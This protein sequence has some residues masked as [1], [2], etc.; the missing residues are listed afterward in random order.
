MKV[1]DYLKSEDVFLFKNCKSKSDLYKNI[2]P[3]SVQTN[4]NEKI[5][6]DKIIKIIDQRE[7]GG[8]LIVK[9]GI[10]MPHARLENI[11]SP[12][13]KF[14]YIKDGIEFEPGRICNFV[15]L[16]ITPLDKSQT[17]LQIMAK[18]LTLFKKEEMMH[19]IKNSENPKDI[20]EIIKQEENMGNI[21]Y[22]SMTKEQVFIELGT[23]VSGFTDEELIEK[24]SKEKNGGFSKL[25]EKLFSFFSSQKE[26]TKIPE[27]LQQFIPLKTKVIRSG[28]KIEIE[29]SELFVGDVV[30][31]EKGDIITAD[32]RVIETDDMKVDN[33][34]L[35]G[36]SIDIYKNS[37]P[38]KT[39]LN[40]LWEELPNMIFAGTRVSRGSGKAIVVATGMNT[41][42]GIT[43]AI[44]QTSK[45]R[46]EKM[47]ELSENILVKDSAD[48]LGTINVICT[49]K[50]GILTIDEMS[51]SRLY[52]NEKEYSISGEGYNP[53]GDYYNEE[54][55]STDKNSLLTDLT[56]KD[57]F[58][59]V[60]SF[61]KSSLIEPKNSN[62]KWSIKGDSLEGALLVL[63]EKTGF[64]KNDLKKIKYFPFDATIKRMS[65]ISENGNSEKGV[66]VKGELLEVL[67]KSDYMNING[68][69][70]ELTVEDRQKIKDKNETY[71]LDGFKVLAFA[72]K[73]VND[74]E[75]DTREDIEKDLIFDAMVGIKDCYKSEI[76]EAIKKC[77]YLKVKVIILTGDNGFNARALARDI[78][79]IDDLDNCIMVTGFE[80]STMDDNK[81]QELLISDKTPI[82]SR[83]EPIQKMRVTACLQNIGNKVAVTA[84]GLNDAIAL[85]NADVGVA[86]GNDLSNAVK[87][88][89][90]MVVIDGSFTSLINEISGKKNKKL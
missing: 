55:E 62:E 42:I 9:E 88:T 10:A 34:M 51:A 33:S 1:T 87:E 20:F 12:I 40:Y 63:A 44:I 35:T 61:N 50:T 66:Y 68:K 70:R 81:L 74:E 75:L 56:F 36:E 78:G 37:E 8:S 38:V 48:I 15:V 59:G 71:I 73:N 16:F 26:T 89:S 46:S 4:K 65:A 53:L 3:S 52:I 80:V 60:F 79:I 11:D 27:I 77:K 49:D 6:K 54:R 22:S 29:S 5:G 7:K 47:K 69:I 17:H 25:T 84:I 72:H 67:E 86:M 23:R 21:N 76:P 57:F 45:H 85:R 43:L 90:N 13:V 32:A 2:L 19:R 28:E 64:V 82:F 83:M 41:E 58:D 14:C 24:C 18:A 30:F 31:F 39:G